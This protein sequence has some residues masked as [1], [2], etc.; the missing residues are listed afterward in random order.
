M[1]VGQRVWYR[2]RAVASNG[3]SSWSNVVSAK[4]PAG[5]P[6]QPANVQA[7][8]DGSN[9]IKLTW[10]E[11]Y[12]T[13]GSQVWGYQIRTSKDPGSGS[14]NGLTLD[15]WYCKDDNSDGVADDYDP[16]GVDCVYHHGSHPPVFPNRDPDATVERPRTLNAGDTW[17]YRVRAT[18][19]VGWGPWSDWVSAT[20]A[21]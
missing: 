15:R 3:N 11:P 9:A 7:A 4:T 18:N 1:Q 8:A 2:I 16:E 12:R 6:G 21:E 5:P 19:R 17:H 13:G 14:W 10:S 20:V